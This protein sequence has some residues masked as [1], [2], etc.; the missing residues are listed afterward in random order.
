MRI[1]VGRL[2]LAMAAGNLLIYFEDARLK[3]VLA[4][5]FTF[6]WDVF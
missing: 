6:L 5:T 2:M 1:A 3:S 4:G